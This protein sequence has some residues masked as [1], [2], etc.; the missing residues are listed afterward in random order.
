[1][2][3]Q[4]NNSTDDHLNHLPQYVRSTPKLSVI[5]LAHRSTQ[6]LA[7]GIA[8]IQMQSFADWE[9]IIVANGVAASSQAVIE[10][11]VQHDERISVEVC[12][13]LNLVQARL[14]GFELAQGKYIYYLDANYVCLPDTLQRLYEAL[15]TKP[16][17]VA[18]YGHVVGMKRTERTPQ[19]RLRR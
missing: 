12:S 7:E 15:E 11:S 1:M 19:S 8:S 17:A 5:L 3:C 14:A 4:V 9:L 16:A 2:K 10:R 6:L 13:N 18:A